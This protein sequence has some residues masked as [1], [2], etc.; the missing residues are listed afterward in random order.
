MRTRHWPLFDLVVRTPRLELRYPDDDLALSLA[1]LAVQGIH[2][3]DTMPFGIPWTDAPPGEQERNSLQHYWL[4]RA[5]WTRE[6]W[7]CPMTVLVD[8]AVAGVQGIEA[9]QFAL[10]REF[11]TGSW[12]G[13]AHQGKGIGKEMR[14]AILHLG[15]AG[16]G[17]RRARTGAFHD[18]QPSLHV[19]AALGYEPNGDSIEPRRDGV[20]RQLRFLMTRERW[21]QRRRQ[22]IEI[23][24]LEPCLE[25][26]AVATS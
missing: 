19:T 4:S 1:Q 26:V 22:D 24:G 5:T 7:G 3:P 2:D 17:A 18:N 15:F 12:L 21:E 11:E 20:D 9:K 8:G 25:M 6:A 14:A 13:R 10:T 23:E 16:L